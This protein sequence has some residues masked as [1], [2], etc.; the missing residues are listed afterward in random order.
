MITY[1]L[2]FIIFIIYIFKIYTFIT[3]KYKFGDIIGTFEGVTAYSN[4][5]DETNN[6]NVN[7]YNNIYTGVKW[8]CVEFVRRYLIIKYGIT[9]SDIDHAFQIPESE[10]TTL[11]GVPVKMTNKLQVGSIIIWPKNYENNSPHGHVAIISNIGISGIY[12]VEQNYDDTNFPRFIPFN[13]L[14]NII[15]LSVP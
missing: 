6:K 4:Q 15:I 13:N 3:R 10:F 8:Q 9:F 7:Y 5:D 12:V 11:N 2:I 1:F 14:Q